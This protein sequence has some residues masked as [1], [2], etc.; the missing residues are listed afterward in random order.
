MSPSD[1]KHAER[2][3]RLTGMRSSEVLCYFMVSP[4][5][6][7]HA[8]RC[9]KTTGMRSSDI[10][11]KGIKVGSADASAGTKCDEE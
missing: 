7:K 11:K 9:E 3:E 5:D 8:R 1:C 10:F 6:C 4:S 2:F